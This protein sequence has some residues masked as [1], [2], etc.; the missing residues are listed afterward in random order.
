MLPASLLSLFPKLARDIEFAELGVFPTPVEPFV[1]PSSGKGGPELHAFVK[2]D[3]L[4]SPVYGGNKVRTLE[5]LLGK[6]LREGARAA[7]STGAYG[8]NH[9]LATALHAPR[10]GLE[11]GA[12]LFPQPLSAVAAE[13]LRVTVTR[14]QR[15]VDLPHWSL[16]PFGIVR[17][18]RAARLRGERVFV[19]VPGGATPHGA[20]GYVAAGLEL[21]LQVSEGVLPPPRA[22]YVGVGSTCTSAGL[23]VGLGLAARFGIGFERPPAL[24]SVRVTPWPVTSAFRILGLARRTGALLNQLTGDARTEFSRAE[25]A[26]RFRIESRFLGAGY[27][28]PTAAGSLA[29]A[30]FAPLGLLLDSTYSEK[31]AAGLLAA[32]ESGEPGPLVFWATKSSAPLPEVT[33]AELMGAPVRMRKWLRASER[34]AGVSD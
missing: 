4:S 15:L 24:V 25:L 34:E 22:V 31:S 5:A 30:R 28:L 19:M 13:N 6:A 26:S 12:M 20:L 29:R 7:F 3:D 10:V 27:G 21:G 33:D 8:S 18:T 14:A 11:A 17:E 2:R 1:I 9:A 16:L 23:L 32:L